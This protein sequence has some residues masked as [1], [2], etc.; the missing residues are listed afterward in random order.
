M[1]ERTA[2][3]GAA[4]VDELRNV[5]AQAEALLDAIARDKDEALSALRERMY[6]ALDAAKDRLGEL[7]E[8][9]SV[10]AR[11]ASVAAETFTRENPWTVVGGALAL[12]LTLGSWFTRALRA[13]DDA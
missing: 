3:R 9:A 8:Q 13:E 11:R 6:G 5:V 2:E 4:L 1:M 10:A 7:E 12:G